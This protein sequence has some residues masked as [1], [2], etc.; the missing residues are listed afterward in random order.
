MQGCI[1][2]C[3]SSNQDHVST[4]LLCIKAEHAI[5]CDMYMYMIYMYH[6]VAAQTITIYLH[7]HVIRPSTLLEDWK[8]SHPRTHNSITRGGIQTYMY[9]HNIMAGYTCTLYMYNVHVYVHVYTWYMYI[10]LHVH[11]I[12]FPCEATCTC[13]HACTHKSGF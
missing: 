4:N 5:K 11:C 10:H 2:P 9:K 8:G 13:V 12:S 1:R 3:S 7:L 6:N